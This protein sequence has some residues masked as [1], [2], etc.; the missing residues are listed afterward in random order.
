ME[1]PVTGSSGLQAVRVW[2]LPT[3]L[4]HWTL[5]SLVICLVVTVFIFRSTRRDLTK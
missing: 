4:F 3:R 2:D 5:V 1:T